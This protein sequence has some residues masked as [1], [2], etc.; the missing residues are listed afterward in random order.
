MTESPNIFVGFNNYF[1]CFGFSP[2]RKKT[3]DVTL[4]WITIIGRLSNDDGDGNENDK[5]NPQVYNFTR[6]LQRESEHNTKIFV[7]FS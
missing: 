2:S 3:C 7:L 5:K 6:P 4:P 1:Q